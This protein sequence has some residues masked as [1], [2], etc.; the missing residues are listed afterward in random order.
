MI[1]E[2]AIEVVHRIFRFFIAEKGPYDIARILHDEKIERPSY[3]MGK[4]GLG[5]HCTTYDTETPYMWRGNMVSATLSKSE[6]MKHTINFRTH[7]ESYKDK[8]AKKSPKDAGL[9]HRTI[10]TA[11]TAT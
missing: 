8:R 7:K 4:Q 10:T 2:E 6:Y 1:D 3:Y 9:P 11:P 5:T